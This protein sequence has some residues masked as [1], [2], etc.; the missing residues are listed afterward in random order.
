MSR[1]GSGLSILFATS[2]SFV[3]IATSPAEAQ[4]RTRKDK[5]KDK[6]RKKRKSEE[7]A[8]VLPGAT[9]ARALTIRLLTKHLAYEDLECVLVMTSTR[10]GEK[11]S[12]PQKIHFRFKDGK[13]FRISYESDGQ[14]KEIF[15]DGKSIVT[16][17]PKTKRYHRLKLPAGASPY[18][19]HAPVIYA[20]LTGNRK[21]F[22]GSGRKSRKPAMAQEVTIGGKFCDRMMTALPG[23]GGL[24][25]IDFLKDGRLLQTTLKSGRNRMTTVTEFTEMKIDSGLDDAFFN[26]RPPPGAIEAKNLMEVAPSKPPTLKMPEYVPNP[27]ESGSGRRSGKR[28]E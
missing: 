22:A 27:P 28:R 5:A 16:W 25:L 11:S 15:C 8:G 18:C 9:T 26:F 10:V 20:L 4:G 21:L 13:R 23:S 6:K 24:L 1:F 7:A 12:E 3:S 17:V 2:L 14:A 19:L